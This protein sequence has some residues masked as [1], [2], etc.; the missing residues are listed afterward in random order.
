ML[1]R[2]ASSTIFVSGYFFFLAKITIFWVAVVSW[3]YCSY[4]LGYI[5]YVLA[6]FFCCCWNVSRKS[7]AVLVIFIVK[8]CFVCEASL[9]SGAYCFSYKSFF[10]CVFFRSY[11]G[12]GYLV[13]L[14]AVSVSGGFVFYFAITSDSLCLPH[15][16]DFLRAFFSYLLYV[17]SVVKFKCISFS[18]LH[19]FLC[20][21]IMC[22]LFVCWRKIS[23]VCVFD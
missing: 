12:L 2:K 17:F 10:F 4:F 22:C 6:Y 15:I 23:I 19:F 13:C 9:F 14:L 18:A 3:Y 20:I 1:S 11:D 5:W 16:A 7:C 21:S 8:W